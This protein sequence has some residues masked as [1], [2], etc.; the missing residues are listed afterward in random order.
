MRLYI[1]TENISTY[2]FRVVPESSAV[3]RLQL[4]VQCQELGHVL[5]CFSDLIELHRKVRLQEG[6]E[7]LVI[8]VHYLRIQRRSC[9]LLDLLFLTV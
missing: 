1:D 5:D 4:K 7:H 3:R 9:V 6:S 2:I 8:E